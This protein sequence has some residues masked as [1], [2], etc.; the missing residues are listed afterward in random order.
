MGLREES[1]GLGL[2]RFGQ[3]R[4][5]SHELRVYDDAPVSL[6]VSYHPKQYSVFTSTYNVYSGNIL[7]FHL[8]LSLLSN[9]QRLISILCSRAKFSS[10]WGRPWRIWKWDDNLEL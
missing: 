8:T 3:S 1:V 7:T 6:A 2:K 10:S 9:P 4:T 5:N